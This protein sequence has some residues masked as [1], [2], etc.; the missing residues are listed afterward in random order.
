[1]NLLLGW[2]IFRGKLAVSFRECMVFFNEF[3]FASWCLGFMGFWCHFYGFF[4]GFFVAQR[5]GEMRG[6]FFD[7]SRFESC[8][9]FICWKFVPFERNFFSIF[10]VTVG[11]PSEQLE[12]NGKSSQGISIS[13]GRF[14]LL[15]AHV[16]AIFK[17]AILCYYH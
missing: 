6:P 8:Q 9:Q 15:K 14:H 2:S 11:L 16:S 3:L 1:M 17:A 4:C 5:V 10:W 13:D 12:M 7:F